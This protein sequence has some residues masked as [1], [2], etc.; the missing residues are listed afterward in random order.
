MCYSYTEAMTVSASAVDARRWSSVVLSKIKSLWSYSSNSL[1]AGFNVITSGK[2]AK[3]VL[4]L[5]V[6]A[7]LCVNECILK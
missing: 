6:F 4:N 2:P 1:M 3:T 5:T 7:C